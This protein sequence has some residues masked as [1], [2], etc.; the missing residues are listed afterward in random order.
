MTKSQVVDEFSRSKY[1]L[2]YPNAFGWTP[3]L[4]NTEYTVVSEKYILSKAIC[5]ILNENINL[6]FTYEV[7]GIY[8]L[9]NINWVL[10]SASHPYQNLRYFQIQNPRQIYFDESISVKFFLRCDERDPYVNMASD[11]YV[12]T[13]E[14]ITGHSFWEDFIVLMFKHTNIRIWDFWIEDSKLYVD[15]H[16]TEAIFFNQGSTGSADRGNRL[17]KTFASLP[18]IDSF[19]ILVGGIHGYETSHYNFAWIALI[20]D[21]SIIEFIEY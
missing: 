13:E 6:L 12:Y 4:L 7:S 3:T 17:L 15:L 11:A 8:P 21:G 16:S 9:R 19:E 14:F 20:E 5:A 18:M 10:K 1:N 2:I